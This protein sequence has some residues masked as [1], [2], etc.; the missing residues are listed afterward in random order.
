MTD[1]AKIGRVV[2][3]GVRHIDG[4]RIFNQPSLIAKSR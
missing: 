3:A 2:R 1:A 4:V